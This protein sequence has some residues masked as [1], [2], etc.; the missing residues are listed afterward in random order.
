MSI[1]VLTQIEKGNKKAIIVNRDGNFEIEFTT[2][3]NNTY[4]ISYVGKDLSYI[5]DAAYNFVCGVFKE[6]DVA[7]HATK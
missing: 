4:I 6:E 2:E 7:N 1:D 3:T 5:E